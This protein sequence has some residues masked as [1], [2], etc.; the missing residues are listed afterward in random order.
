M[1]NMTILRLIV[2]LTLVIKFSVASADNS[3]ETIVFPTDATLI[4]STFG[5]RRLNNRFDFH[6]GIDIYGT[7]QNR[8]FAMSD[9]TVSDVTTSAGS[10]LIEHPNLTSSTGSSVFSRYTHLSRIDVEEGDVVTAGQDIG[11]MGNTNALLVHLHFEV[12]ED[13]HLSLDYQLNN[14][15]RTCRTDPCKDPHVHPFNYLRLDD[16]NP[17]N[18]EV[19]SGQGE[20][21][22]IKATVGA[23]EL[24]INRFEIRSP[25][26]D[27]I[28][29]D[30]NGRQGFDPTSN[31][32]LDGNPVAS[33][34]EFEVFTF[35]KGS[36]ERG[37][38]FVVEIEFP[39]VLEYSSIRVFDTYGNVTEI[40]DDD[41][42]LRLIPS[43]VRQSKR[44][45]K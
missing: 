23:N 19:I 18:V 33:G 3:D 9:G 8:I 27:V 42:L 40:S 34:P 26:I 38:D 15:S 24:D 28:T 39:G 4:V 5:P 35:N 43:I 6:R 1:V 17:P 25:G 12:R 29:L 31:D 36:A 32:N 45:P 14:G 41:F 16:N 11:R 7:T 37:D 20:P 30:Y 22:R 13:T 10:I 44:E 21:L 2:C